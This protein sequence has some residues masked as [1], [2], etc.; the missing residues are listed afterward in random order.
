MQNKVF[1]NVNV[2]TR[3]IIT[4]LLSL[5]ILIANSV[6]LMIFLSIL[7]LFMIILTDKSVKQYIYF[8]KKLKFWLLFIFIAYIIISRNIIDSLLFL[9]KLTL[10]ICLL[11]QLS[12]TVNFES[13][14]DGVNTLLKK[15]LKKNSEQISY[16]TTLILYFIGFYINTSDKINSLHKSNKLGSKYSFKKYIL[17]R[18]FMATTEI[19]EL[20]NSLKLKCYKPKIETKNM[21]SI[22]LLVVFLVL[23][24]VVIFKEVIL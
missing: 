9:Y 12:L 16:N 11:R 15:I 20:E 24:T 4:L 17:P 6:Y 2:S 23:F 13:L 8:I 19:N 1:N 18:F 5:S 3:I 7:C 21:G 14:N 22:L 10:V